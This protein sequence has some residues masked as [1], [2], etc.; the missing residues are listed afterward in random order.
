MPRAR[1]WMEPGSELTNLA[2]AMWGRE[3]RIGGEGKGS[4][5][6]KATMW[7]SRAKELK[8]SLHYAPRATCPDM[9]PGVCPEEGVLFLTS[10]RAPYELVVALALT[11][12]FLTLKLL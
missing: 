6:S 1:L 3:V 11:L 10:T 12:V 4:L 5:L 2:P 7:G 8:S 9:G